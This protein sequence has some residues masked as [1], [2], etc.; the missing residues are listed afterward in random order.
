MFPSL[1]SAQVTLD[2]EGCLMNVATVGLDRS[3]I[4]LIRGCTR[5]AS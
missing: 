4:C 3:V 5:A 2:Q 1:A